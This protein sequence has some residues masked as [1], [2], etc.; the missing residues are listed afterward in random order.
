MRSQRMTPARRAAIA[1]IAALLLG[2]MAG[3]GSAEQ[4][5]TAEPVDR[6]S[7]SSHSG[8]LLSKLDDIL[9]RDQAIL[10]RFDEIMQE[11]QVV[12]IRVLRRPT[13]PTP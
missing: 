12:K 13:A 11:L 4:G 5:T 1:T 10:S 2:L 7:R 3:D 9:S 6:S 8:M